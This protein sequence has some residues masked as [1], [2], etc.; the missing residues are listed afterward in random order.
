MSA[1]SGGPSLVALAIRAMPSTTRSYTDSW[2]NRRDPAQQFWPWLAKIPIAAPG[3]RRRDPHLRARPWATCRRVPESRTSSCAAAA[4][5]IRRPICVEP[6]KLILSTCG[7]ATS[8]APAVS[9]SPVTTLITPSGIPASA[10]RPAKR[11]AVSGVCSAGLRTMVHP[12]AK[13]GAIFQMALSQRG[14]SRA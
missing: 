3:W 8:A 2:T 10:T 6:V 1:A 13:A 11:S 4:S 9:P 14:H 5:P 7:W 12:V